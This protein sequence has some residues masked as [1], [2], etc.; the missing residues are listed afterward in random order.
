[1][2]M[3][4]VNL[5]WSIIS[6]GTQKKKTYNQT[7]KLLKHC[8]KKTFE[9]VILQQNLKFSICTRQAGS[10]CK[11]FSLSALRKIGLNNPVYDNNQKA[12]TL[13]LKQWDSWWLYVFFLDLLG[14]VRGKK[15]FF[16]RHVS[17]VLCQGRPPLV[18]G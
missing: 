3:K 6:K 14:K 13:K 2:M 16:E 8:L 10:F 1:M 15:T 7:W 17:Q 12:A 18:P 5:V 4:C 11:L 9:K